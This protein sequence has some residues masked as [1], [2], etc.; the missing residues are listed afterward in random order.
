MKATR[1][2]LLAT[3][4]IGSLGV[5]LPTLAGAAEA[6]WLELRSLHTG[7]SL[8]VHWDAD[9]KLDAA[10]LGRLR[11]LLRD[12]RNGAELDMD[13]GLFDLLA[14]LAMQAKTEP[15]YEIISGFRSP[16]TNAKLH[17]RSSGVAEKSLHIQG[18]AIDVRLRGVDTLRLAT[19]ARG[20]RR[21]G[22]GYYKGDGFVHVDTGRVRAW[23]G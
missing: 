10:A 22:V 1:R 23:D 4:S 11:H 20:L 12:H 14:D 9:G 13:A 21:G 17:D 6:R 18:R 3:L 19:L 2:A 16:E 5:L 8:T 7:E 15:R